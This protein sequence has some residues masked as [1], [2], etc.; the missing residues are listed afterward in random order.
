MHRIQQ[1]LGHVAPTESQTPQVREGAPFGRR[2]LP[3]RTERN[4]RELETNINRGRETKTNAWTKQ[5]L[6]GKC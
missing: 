1:A 2:Q 4:E 6:A 5:T 3:N